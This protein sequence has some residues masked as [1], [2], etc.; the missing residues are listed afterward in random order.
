MLTKLLY[1][2]KLLSNCKV[3]LLSNNKKKCDIKHIIQL[4]YTQTQLYYVIFYLV[5]CILLIALAGTFFL[6]LNNDIICSG[7]MFLS[8]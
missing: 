4:N 3:T 5:F 7:F 1:N 2:S 8:L 6:H